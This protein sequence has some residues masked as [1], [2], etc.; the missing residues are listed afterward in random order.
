LKPRSSKGFFLREDNSELPTG[1][2]E[3]DLFDGGQKKHPKR[4]NPPGTGERRGDCLETGICKTI[5]E[6]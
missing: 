1:K 2:E 6:R 5:G 3:T 4:D